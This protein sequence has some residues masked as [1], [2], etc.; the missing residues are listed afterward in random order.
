MCLKIKM[1]FSHQG[2]DL[3]NVISIGN[4]SHIG[5]P[6]GPIQVK[7]RQLEAIKNAHVIRNL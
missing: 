4:L 6:P 1:I 3:S 7:L 2:L 5:L